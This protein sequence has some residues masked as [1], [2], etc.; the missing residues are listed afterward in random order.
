[1]IVVSGMPL[2][3]YCLYFS[4][5]YFTLI[6]MWNSVIIKIMFLGLFCS[7]KIQDRK[8]IAYTLL[9]VLV[10]EWLGRFICEA[11]IVYQWSLSLIGWNHLI[12]Y[13]ERNGLMGTTQECYVLFWTY[14]GS[15]TPQKKLYGHLSTISQIRL[16]GEVRMNSFLWTPTTGYWPSRLG[17]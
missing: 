14:P 4:M 3:I 6:I 10:V 8:I 1:M 16:S 12:A 5:V 9:G 7:D 11:I 15:N 13:M 17:L 2:G